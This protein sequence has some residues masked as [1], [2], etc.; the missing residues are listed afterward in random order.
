MELSSLKGIGPARE[1]ALRAMGINSLR[2]LLYTMPVRYEDYSTVFPCN[3]KA[4]G[5]VL[6]SGQFSGAAKLSV[7]HGL[8]KVTATLEDES[9]KLLVCWYNMPW[10]ANAVPAGRQVRLFGR[11]TIKNGRRTLQNPRMLTEEETGLFP[12]YRNGKAF[13]SKSFRKLIRTALESVDDCCPETLPSEFRLRYQLC[14]L[15][16]AIRQAHFPQNIESLKAARRRLSFEKILLYLL[17]VSISGS[18]KQPARGIRFPEDTAGRFWSSLPFEPTGA[19]RKVLDQIASDL[20]KET[21]M[22]RLVQGDVGCGKTAVAFGA[23]CLAAR[24]GFQASMMA[25]TEVLASQ[26]YQNAK[27][28]LEPLGIRCRLLTGS[29][30]AKERKQ[31]LQELKD[32][33]CDLL[34]GTH[35]LISQDVEYSRLGLVITDEQHRFGVNQRSTLQKKGESQGCVPHVLVM[36]ATPIP[37][38]MA[39]ILYGDLDL[40]VIDELP[41]GRMPVKTRIVPE[42]KREDLYGFIRQEAAKGKQAYIVCPL[43]EDSD[44]M[45]ELQSAKSVFETLQKNELKGLRIA[46]TWGNQKADEKDKVLREFCGGRYDVLVS[47]TVIEVG[48]NNPNATIMVIENAERY[49]LSQLH[50]LRGRVGRGSAESWCFLFSDHPD[51]L[52]ILCS[53]ND[54]FLISQTDLEQRGPG[55]LIGTRQAGEPGN[56][57]LYADAR[58]LDEAARCVQE[59]HRSES[60]SGTLEKLE[61]YA[62]SYFAEQGRQVALN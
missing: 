40:S 62:V 38:T 26:H 45:E 46:L 50:Q 3:T 19:Q 43:V 41:G 16:F 29:T 61:S 42:H 6:V 28:M 5:P 14:E 27:E 54:G 55:D 58:M 20:K 34:I 31:I 44:N 18:R 57:Y 1:E 37:R 8:R 60:L 56:E 21:A 22:S 11:L 24:G 53:T 12:V 32:Q 2:D 17:F 59:L 49:G 30:K 9:G 47:T 35:A 23:V 48:V 25:P 51:K 10:I 4:E 7:Y 13:P 39:L 15:N 33:Q 52:K 36:S